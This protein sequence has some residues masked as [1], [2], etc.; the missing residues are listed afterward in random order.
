MFACGN[1]G[2]DRY[3]IATRTEMPISEDATCITN[4]F[5]FFS[6]VR[7]HKRS[8]V[9][10]EANKIAYQTQSRSQTKMG[11]GNA[12]VP[13]HVLETFSQL[14]LTRIIGAGEKLILRMGM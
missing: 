3:S 7:G 8:V 6:P 13:I 14:G 12:V 11:S 1:T 9:L 4:H 5:L 10:P 2:R